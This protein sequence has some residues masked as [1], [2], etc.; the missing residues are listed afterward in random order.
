MEDLYSYYEGMNGISMSLRISSSMARLSFVADQCINPQ[1]ALI[2]QLFVEGVDIH[3]TVYLR[4]D[5]L[6][7]AT[8]TLTISD[9]VDI[10]RKH[11]IS[12]KCAE[13]FHYAIH[14]TKYFLNNGMK[15][16]GN[17]AISLKETDFA[18]KPSM[19]DFVAN[20]SMIQEMDSIILRTIYHRCRALAD[21][22][23]MPE[24]AYL[25]T[26]TEKV[27]ADEAVTQR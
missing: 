8:R 2:I 7:H 19:Y 20:E 11:T 15:Q 4:K 6:D 27:F 24:L 26:V 25:T 12:Q 18:I 13:L 16:T 17:A 22:F 14:Q 23:N 21:V 10:I 1:D 3:E 5:S 9:G